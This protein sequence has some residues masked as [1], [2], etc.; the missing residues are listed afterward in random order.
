MN[1]TKNGEESK[2]LLLLERVIED[3]DLKKCIMII[4]IIH[5]QG[6]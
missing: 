3:L 5:Y 1:E 4:R 6:F 2:I